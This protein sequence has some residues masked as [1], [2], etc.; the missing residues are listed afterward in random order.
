MYALIQQNMDEFKMLLTEG[1]QHKLPKQ[2]QPLPTAD[3]VFSI[4][5][6]AQEVLRTA[7]AGRAFVG[8]LV[9]EPEIK[10]TD[11]RHEPSRR[12]SSSLTTSP[13]T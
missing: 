2:A 12:V 8:V 3:E 5:R 6:R 1:T 4:P 13:A 10:F 7:H 9:M 11:A